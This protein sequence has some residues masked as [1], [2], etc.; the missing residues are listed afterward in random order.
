MLPSVGDEIVYTLR[1]EDVAFS[2][3]NTW[4]YLDFEGEVRQTVE[5][6]P[7]GLGENNRP[8]DPDDPENHVLLKTTFLS[9]R[10]ERDGVD[11]VSIGLA[12]RASEFESRLVVGQL[13]PPQFVHRSLLLLKA[14]VHTKDGTVEF[15]ANDPLL[16]DGLITRFPPKDDHYRAN[17]SVYFKGPEER[18]DPYGM[19]ENVA[20]LNKFQARMDSK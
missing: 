14:G 18:D 2:Y 1:A 4:L 11:H 17:D 3:L 20:I 7:E 5:S 13:S 16:L 12:D 6:V 10:G 19:Y 9:L 15:E 8:G